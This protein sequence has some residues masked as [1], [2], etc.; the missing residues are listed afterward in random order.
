[1]PPDPRPLR[2]RG[3]IAKPAAPA[4]NVAK[5]LLQTLAMWGVLLF[6]VP[7]LLAWLEARTLG[8][9]FDPR[10]GRAVA[11][12][13]F[14]VCGAFGISN[15]VLL[16]TRGRGT[17]L[18]LD[19]TNALVLAGPYRHVR[20]PMAMASLLQGAAVGVF[21]GSPLVLAYAL[22]GALVW[23]FVARP[24]EERDLDARFGAPYRDY[25]E[26]VRCWIPRA[27]PYE[28]ERAI[29]EPRVPVKR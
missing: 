28:P 6:A 23:N 22:A 2:I 9:G 1:M 16:A 21:V 14:V 5:T 13:V 10:A 24:W 15:G 7:S 27:S 4:V 11:A 29:V 18:P 26:N 20:N 19:S 12:A 25:V 8:T 17:P 3:R